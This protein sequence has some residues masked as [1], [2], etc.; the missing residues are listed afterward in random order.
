MPQT[1][2]KTAY[3]SALADERLTDYLRSRGCR[4]VSV[5]PLENLA[6]PVACHPDLL[7]CSL[8]GRI[9]AG[10]PALLKPEYP[11]DVLYNAAAVGEYFLCSKYTHPGLIEASGRTPVLLPQGYVKCNLVV[12]DEGHVITEDAGIARDLAKIPEIEC[13]KIEAGAVKLPGYSYGFLGGCSGRLEDEMIFSGNLAAHP[14]YP[15]IAAFLEGCGLK[16][17]Y[18]PEFPL[19]DIGSI[20]ISENE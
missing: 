3:V 11:G 9:Y 4:V 18:F 12:A 8:G 1:K 17:K 6:V 2:T 19:T 5:G 15:E 10:D 20:L 7:Y 14:Q 16:I 13:L